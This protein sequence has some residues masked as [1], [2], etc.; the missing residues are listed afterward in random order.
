M[1]PYNTHISENPGLTRQI[2]QSLGIGEMAMTE[3]D[4]D[5]LSVSEKILKTL[6]RAAGSMG[7]CVADHSFSVQD[8]ND[9]EKSPPVSAYWIAETR[10]LVLCTASVAGLHLIKVPEKSW[11]I[12]PQTTH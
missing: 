4:F 1:R 9:Q 10:E 6:F 5:D 12:K 2:A 7:Q 3:V 8:G 11:T